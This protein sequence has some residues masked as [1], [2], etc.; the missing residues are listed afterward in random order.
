MRRHRQFKIFACSNGFSREKRRDRKL[1]LFCCVE[2]IA[3]VAFFILQTS[4]ASEKK[5]KTSS[6]LQLS[7]R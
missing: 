4:S 6:A 2:L 7:T 1:P 5:D 3:Y